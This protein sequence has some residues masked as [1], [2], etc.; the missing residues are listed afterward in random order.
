MW[1][2]RAQDHVNS[3]G[4]DTSDMTRRVFFHFVERDASDFCVRRT[5][6]NERKR[7][8]PVSGDGW[9]Y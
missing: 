2:H 1:L 3:V 7:T 9:I 4:L 6:V 5:L 8:V